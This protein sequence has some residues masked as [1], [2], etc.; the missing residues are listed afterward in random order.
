MWSGVTTNHLASL[1]LSLIARWP[2]LSGLYHVSSGRASKFEVLHLIRDAYNLDVEI[3]PD[4]NYVLDRTLSGKKLETAI[5]YR[6]PSLTEQIREMAS[7][8]TQY[9]P[10]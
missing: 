3:R 2:T 4:D 10:L 6:C 9:R 7:D 1:I 8:P 5:A